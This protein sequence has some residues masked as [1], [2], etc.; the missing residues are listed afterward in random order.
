MRCATSACH[1]SLAASAAASW[2]A[3]KPASQ[4][5]SVST[6]EGEPLPSAEPASPPSPPSGALEAERSLEKLL[7]VATEPPAT[8]AKG[9]LRLVSLGAAAAAA[10]AAAAASR[11]G[12]S[13]LQAGRRGKERGKPQPSEHRACQRSCSMLRVQPSNATAIQPAAHLLVRLE[14]K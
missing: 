14:L 13:A 5:S 4:A 8:F 3:K 11:P 9:L 12:L 10:V 7:G 1:S 6:A 2:P